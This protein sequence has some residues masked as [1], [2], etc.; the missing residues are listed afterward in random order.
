MNIKGVA[1]TGSVL[2]RDPIV[3]KDTIVTLAP[4]AKL[5]CQGQLIGEITGLEQRDGRWMYTAK[6]TDPAAFAKIIKNQ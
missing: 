4:G 3:T 6:I 2:T 1:I 5:S